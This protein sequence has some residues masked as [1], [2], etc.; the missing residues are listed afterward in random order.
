MAIKSYDVG[1][2]SWLN[3]FN[4]NSNFN[5]NDHNLNNHNSLRGIAHY[6][7]ETLLL[8]PHDLWKELCSIQ[9]LELAYKNERKHKTLRTCIL[10][11]EE[12]LTKNLDLLR[13]ELLFHSYKPRP[14]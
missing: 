4:N 10:E 13:T 12:N 6:N 1:R 3:N 9:N 11:F 8:K 2:A 14:L 5:A 7:A